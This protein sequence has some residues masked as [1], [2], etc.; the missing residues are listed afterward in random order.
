MPVGSPEGR[1]KRRGEGGKKEGG[2]ARGGSLSF[3]PDA[4]R[5]PQQR[6]RG[7]GGGGRQRA[8]GCRKGK[9]HAGGGGAAAAASPGLERCCEEEAAG[10]GRRPGLRGSPVRRAHGDASPAPAHSH[11]AGAGLQR[12]ER[13]PPRLLPPCRKRALRSP[14]H[15]LNGCGD[16]EE[17][18]GERLWRPLAE[19]WVS[20]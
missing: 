2:R 10:G 12:S 20:G 6:G 7:G 1:E 4:T 15:S 16:K 14:V 5:N 11:P 18:E 13:A 8:R 17:E 9:E 19:D 3:V